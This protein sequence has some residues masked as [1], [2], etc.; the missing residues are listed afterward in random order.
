MQAFD[1]RTPYN[2]NVRQFR[3]CR[4][5]ES[6]QD[7]LRQQSHDVMSECQAARDMLLVIERAEVKLKTRYNERSDA[8]LLVRQYHVRRE[9]VRTAI[10]SNSVE[11]AEQP[12]HAMSTDRA[13]AE[14]APQKEE[15]STRQTA[16]ALAQNKHQPAKHQHALKQVTAGS[17][18]TH[19]YSFLRWLCRSFSGRR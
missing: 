7:V 1:L 4:T 19:F 11:L 10:T 2:L 9:K 6:F 18:T 16:T 12:S 14:Q 15:Q 17:S 8:W 13:S 3:G 5:L